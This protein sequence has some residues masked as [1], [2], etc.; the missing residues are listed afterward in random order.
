MKRIVRRGTSASCAAFKHPSVAPPAHPID[1][2]R[3]CETNVPPRGRGTSIIPNEEVPVSAT[4]TARQGQPR[5]QCKKV[6]RNALSFSLKNL[7][8][9]GQNAS[10]LTTSFIGPSGMTCASPACAAVGST[11]LGLRAVARAGRRVWKEIL[12]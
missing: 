2:Q 12:G 4:T 7:P 1:P 10:C 6:T 8:Q 5:S 11:T 3:T 9:S